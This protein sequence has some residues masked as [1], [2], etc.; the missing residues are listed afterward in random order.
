MAR[1]MNAGDER[2]TPEFME[3]LKTKDVSRKKL[4]RN[5]ELLEQYHQE[6]TA[7]TKKRRRG[8]RSRRQNRNQ[9]ESQGQSET[10]SSF[11]LPNLDVGQILNGIQVAT[12]VMKSFQGL[13]LFG[14]TPKMFDRPF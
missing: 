1:Q 2:M 13:N 8:L 4:R 3:W 14:S 6:W 12:Q 11:K 10:R 5:P 7:S 9:I